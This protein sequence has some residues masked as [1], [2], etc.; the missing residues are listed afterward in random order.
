MAGSDAE[1]KAQCRSC[2]V[3]VI[4]LGRW[5]LDI[6][7]HLE[8]KLQKIAPDLNPGNQIPLDFYCLNFLNLFWW[9]LWYIFNYTADKLNKSASFKEQGIQELCPVIFTFSTLSLQAM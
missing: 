5:P 1:P 7:E 9:A 4:Y 8:I 6:F 2:S 3:F